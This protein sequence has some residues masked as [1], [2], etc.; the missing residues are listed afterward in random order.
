MY[1]DSENSTLDKIKQHREIYN[2]LVTEIAEKEIIRDSILDSLVRDVKGLF[3]PY[4]SKMLHEA[5]YQQHKEEKAD[6]EMYEFLK[7]DLIENLFNKEDK[8]KLKQIVGRGYEGYSY[9]FEFQVGKH[10]LE[11]RIPDISKV[12]KKNV[13]DTNCGQ[14]ELSRKIGDSCC[15]KRMTSSYDLDEIARTIRNYLDAEKEV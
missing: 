2:K 10:V 4:S 3:I 6:R 13:F 11:V 12:T 5:F 1:I 7:K 14:Y 8:A 9:G 15:W